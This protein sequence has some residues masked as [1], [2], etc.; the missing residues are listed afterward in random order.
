MLAAWSCSLLSRAASHWEVPIHSMLCRK[1]MS[2]WLPLLFPLKVTANHSALP[3]SNDAQDKFCLLD[4]IQACLDN[5]WCENQSSLGSKHDQ[6]AAVCWLRMSCI[7]P[8]LVVESQL[9]WLRVPE[10][11]L[12]KRK[13]K[14]FMSLFMH[15]QNFKILSWCCAGIKNL[16]KHCFA[17][18]GVFFF[19]CFF[20]PMFRS[21]CTEQQLVLFCFLSSACTC[22][23]PVLCLSHRHTSHDLCK[24]F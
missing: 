12:W 4:M 2:T 9:I 8:D 1:P 11:C 23:C 21:V 19:V 3:S 22:Q 10:N 20:L 13:N 17:I 16:P 6:G 15:C 5:A 24:R 18:A 14:P 7:V